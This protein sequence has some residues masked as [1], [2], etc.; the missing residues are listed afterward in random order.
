MVLILLPLEFRG[1]PEAASK[2]GEQGCNKL[3]SF[4]ATATVAHPVLALN[5]LRYLTKQL[6]S[7]LAPCI[8]AGSPGWLPN[9][10][11]CASQG[12]TWPSVGSLSA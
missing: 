2:V 4:P 10:S 9:A 1:R 8:I 3:I 5:R 11:A 7:L 12:E 6:R